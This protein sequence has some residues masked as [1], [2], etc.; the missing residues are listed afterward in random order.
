MHHLLTAVEGILMREFGRGTLGTFRV[1]LLDAAISVL[2]TPI[3]G[4]RPQQ[5][6]PVL[7]AGCARQKT[8]VAACHSFGVGFIV[9][10][11][12]SKKQ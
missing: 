7:C 1:G 5:V 8:H 12:S 10:T 3:E 6:S 2:V 9:F 4:L 11:P